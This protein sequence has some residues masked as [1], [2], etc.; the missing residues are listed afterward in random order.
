MDQLLEVDAIDLG[1]QR[2][3]DRLGH[4][5]ARA[6]VEQAAVAEQLGRAVVRERQR[7]AVAR[8]LADLDAAAVDEEQRAA[9]IAGEVDDVAATRLAQLDALGHPRDRI[10]TEVREQRY[11][12]EVPEDALRDPARPNCSKP[13]AITGVQLLA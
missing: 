11:L 7:L 12:A 6:A 9:R 4:L 13:S 5:G 1:E 8:D 2:V 3:L 10:G